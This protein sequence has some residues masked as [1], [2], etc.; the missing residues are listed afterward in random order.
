[1]L[2]WPVQ[3]DGEWATAPHVRRAMGTLRAAGWPILCEPR[4][5]SQKV[6]RLARADE[7]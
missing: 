4:E 2:G 1:M 3:M 6:F 5:D 7:L